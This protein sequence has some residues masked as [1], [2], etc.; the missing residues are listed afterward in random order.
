[1][2]SLVT[3]GSPAFLRLLATAS[4]ASSG[5]HWRFLP[6]FTLEIFLNDN[7]MLPIDMR[8]RRDYKKENDDSKEKYVQRVG[9]KGKWKGKA[10]K[11]RVRILRLLKRLN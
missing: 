4:F 11:V 10:S 8:F 7:V 9:K 6:S 2:L 3:Y 1:M 5:W